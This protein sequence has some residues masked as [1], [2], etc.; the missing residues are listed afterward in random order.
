MPVRDDPLLPTPQVGLQLGAG[1]V[2]ANV[3]PN[4]KCDAKTLNSDDRD[5]EWSVAGNDSV[6]GSVTRKVFSAPSTSKTY[7]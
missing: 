6:A 4:A 3:G 5:L 7:W 1:H 2:G